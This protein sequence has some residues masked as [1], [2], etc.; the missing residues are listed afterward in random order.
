MQPNPGMM[1]KPGKGESVQPVLDEN[2]MPQFNWHADAFD[3]NGR[4]TIPMLRFPGNANCMA[5]HITSNSR[6]GFFG[7]G[8]DLA[9]RISLPVRELFCSNPLSAGIFKVAKST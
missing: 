2:G 7:F 8:E 3:D 1:G 6:R 5:C 9:L 4:V